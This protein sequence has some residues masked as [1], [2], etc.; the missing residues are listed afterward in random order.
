VTRARLDV[1][2]VRRG[3]ARSRG[4]AREL[5]AAGRVRVADAIV[6]KPATIVHPDEDVALDGEV[7]PWVGRA[8]YKLLAALE[9]WLPRG[10]EVTGTRCLDVGAST[11]GFT[12]VLLERGAAHVVALDVG[13][14]QLAPTVRDD[15][16]VTERSGT[17]IREVTAADLGGPFHVIVADLS[18]ISLRLVLPTITGLLGPSGQ[19]VVLV[20]PQF[21]VGRERLGKGGVVRSVADRRGAVE[22]VVTAAM[23]AGLHPRELLPSPLPGESGNREYLVWMTARSAPPT[24]QDLERVMAQMESRP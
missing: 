7:D 13:H 11:G 9:A 21:E 14:D 20:K 19:V 16:R 22:G 18:F 1:E 10:L 8:A 4:Q 24:A 5:L 15:P 17:S 23:A 2:L 12:Q 3:L 6:D